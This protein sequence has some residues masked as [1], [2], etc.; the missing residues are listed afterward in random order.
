MK[1][2]YVKADTLVEACEQLISLLQTLVQEA[3]GLTPQQVAL[4]PNEVATAPE[5]APLVDPAALR[6]ECR[7]LCAQIA[8]GPER[9]TPVLRILDEVAGVRKLDAVPADRLPDVHAALSQYLR[10]A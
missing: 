1:E 2:A 3:K 6:E 9:A 8:T 5:T 7:A 4:E 10:A